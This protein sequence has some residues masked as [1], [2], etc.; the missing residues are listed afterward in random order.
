MRYNASLWIIPRILLMRHQRSFCSI[1]FSHSWWYFS[2]KCSQVFLSFFCVINHWRYLLRKNNVP[3]DPTSSVFACLTQLFRIR[4]IH[5]LYT[6]Q[7]VNSYRKSLLL[8]WFV[9]FQIKY[10]PPLWNIGKNDFKS[11]WPQSAVCQLFEIW[12]ISHSQVI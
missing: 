6:I 3:D 2:F 1:L 10:L 11:Q 9:C 5:H 8:H 12:Q 7:C 4:R